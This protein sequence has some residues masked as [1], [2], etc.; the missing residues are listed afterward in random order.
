MKFR[1][2]RNLCRLLFRVGEEKNK[3]TKKKDKMTSL[4][5]VFFSFLSSFSTCLMSS[6]LLMIDSVRQGGL[7]PL[8]EGREEKKE[9]GRESLCLRSSI[10]D[11]CML[12]FHN[13]CKRRSEPL[14]PWRE[15][16]IQVEIYWHFC[17]PL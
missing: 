11:E 16:Q 12:F 10:L 17:F 8:Q 9:G 4:L 1:K 13:L 3:K 2:G 15:V 5:V 7:G 6:A 14:F